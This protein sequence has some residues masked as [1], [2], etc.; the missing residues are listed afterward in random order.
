[1]DKNKPYDIEL[2]DKR[3]SRI[4]I[5]D[6]LPQLMRTY[7]KLQVYKVKLNDSKLDHRLFLPV[8]QTK[9][10]LS[11][12]ILEGTQATL[13]DVLEERLEE[14]SHSD[15]VVEIFNC[16]QAIAYGAAY[17]QTNRITEEMLHELHK[18]LMDGKVHKDS[19]IVGGFRNSQNYVKNRKT[20][21]VTYTPPAPEMI[22]KSM[23]N[24]FSYMDVQCPD[25]YELIRVAIIHAQFETIHPYYDGN[26]RVG[27]IL[28]PLYLY[29][30][31]VIDSPFF[32]ISDAFETNRVKYYKLL[33]NLR[34]MADWNNWI[35]YF[36]ETMEMQCD[37]Y[38]KVVDEIN[39]L[40]EKDLNRIL[41]KI[42]ADKAKALIELLFQY[43]VVNANTIMKNLDIQ[44][45]TAKRYLEILEMEGILYSDGK[46]RYIRYY[47]NELLQ[48]LM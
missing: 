20:G 16:Y 45:N 42:R 38:I 21:Q 39:R 46:E 4:E 14:K 29:Y 23:Q 26:G 35:S 27:R 25:Y 2:L 8:L 3:D 40:Y 15:E 7:S 22:S 13:E 19:N 9:E 36:L 24:L 17:L 41:E 28:I 43:P 47:Y 10:A 11:S 30:K 33:M 32:F 6:F 1:M 44:R 18:I 5:K 31:K 48:L 12:S 37:K 34:E